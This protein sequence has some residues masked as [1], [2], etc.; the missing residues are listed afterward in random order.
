M[1]LSEYQPAFL[2]IEQH[3]T[4]VV[5]RLTR[6]QLSEEDN[7]DQMAHELVTLIDQYQCLQ[8]ALSL[9]TVEYITS[10]ALGKLIH[11]HRKLHRL[12][13]RLVMCDVQ[14][15]VAEIL[16][17]SRLD[18]YFH[19]ADNCEQALGQLLAT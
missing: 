2:T 4:V 8:L 5:A 9:G 18:Q 10:A 12:D 7:I 13:G 19:I 11:V 15:S 16:K 6:P 14:T 3:G 1:T 17:T